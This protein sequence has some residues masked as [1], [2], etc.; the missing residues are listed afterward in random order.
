VRIFF[1]PDKFYFMGHSQGGFTGPL[2]LAL[3]PSI[4][5][6]VL[7]GAGAAIA[8]GALTKREPVDVKSLITMGLGIPSTEAFDEFNILINFVQTY[9]ERSD[10]MNYAPR[11]VE[12]P[13]SGVSKNILMTEGLK[14]DY[15]SPASVEALA[16]SIGVTP[17]IPVSKPV[18]GLLLK[19]RRE[20][21]KPLR[22]NV[23]GTATAA[24]IQYPDGDH[25]VALN[26]PGA[27][28]IWKRFF[29][30]LVAD[31]VATIE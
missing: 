30:T 10:A 21:A 18:E 31:G 8:V 26:D 29:E 20:T 16:I 25:W 17:V 7:S 28:A 27:I 12:S 14:D 5:G 22:G 2:F 1:N 15:A 24:L 19:G 4:K 23:K 6:A 3:E 13:P 11:I 9:F